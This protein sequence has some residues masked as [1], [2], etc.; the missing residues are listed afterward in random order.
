ML[1]VPAPWTD[2]VRLVLSFVHTPLYGEVIAADMLDSPRDY[3][4]EGNCRL[5]ATG[6]KKDA[7]PPAGIPDT[8]ESDWR[9]MAPDIPPTF[10]HVRI[11]GRRLASLLGVGVHYDGDSQHSG[12]GPKL[13]YH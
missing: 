12:P 2:T 9:D 8:N 1:W 5:R 11:P 7:R 6:G 13:R 3:L 4:R 10:R